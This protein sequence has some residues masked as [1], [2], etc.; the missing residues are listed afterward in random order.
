MKKKKVLQKIVGLTVSLFNN[1]G[2]ECREAILLKL[3]DSHVYCKLIETDQILKIPIQSC[4]CE[5]SISTR[6]KSLK[7]YKLKT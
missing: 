2:Y 3:D 1:S 6:V 5:T 4:S 7:K